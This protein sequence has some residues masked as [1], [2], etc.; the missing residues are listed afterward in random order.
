MNSLEHFN[1]YFQT[2]SGD[3][4]NASLIE[5][6]R[7]VVFERLLK[8]E[9]EILDLG[10]GTRSIFEDL[11]VVKEKVI[12]VDF[13]NVAIEKTPSHTTINYLVVDLTTPNAFGKSKFDLIFD[14]HC[15]HCIEGYSEREVA[16][17]NIYNALGEDGLFCAEM[18]IQK[19]YKYVHLPFK[20][21]PTALELEREILESGLKI[22]YF[23]I[24]P[25]MVFHN[26]NGECDLLRVVCRK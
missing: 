4:S 18:M 22:I 16:F 25:G 12:A 13:S 14:S 5:F 10:C 17:K 23:L 11:N 8:S 26:E 24:S 2:A 1:H 19:S 6:Y 20:H 9:P 7:S 15:L 21:V 3:Q